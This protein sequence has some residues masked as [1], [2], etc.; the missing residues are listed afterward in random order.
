MIEERAER[1]TLK[2]QAWSN[3]KF[4]KEEKIP[5][6]S[7][8]IGLF[9]EIN[10]PREQA[11]LVLTYLTAGRI[12]E[13]VQ[14]KGRTSIKKSDMKVVKENGRDILLIDLRNQ[15]NKEKHRK[16]IPVPLDITENALLWN[17]IDGYI[18]PLEKDEE[19]FPFSYQYAYERITKLTGWNPHWIRHLRLTHLVTVYGY[20]EYQ[21][22]RYAGWTDSRPAKNY[23]EMNW[24]DLLY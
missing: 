7:D 14:K 24:K 6:V 13:I 9:A 12:R 10:S 3:Q 22:V 15:K 4:L 20:K 23:V 19:L 1:S 11:L 5:T 17:M 16:D 18:N 8:V 2:P 21:L